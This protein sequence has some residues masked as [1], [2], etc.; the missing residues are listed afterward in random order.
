LLSTQKFSSNVVERVIESAEKN[1][2]N[3]IVNEMF[4]NATNFMILMKNK[5]GAFVL[6]KV[7]SMMQP[8]EKIIIKG[9]L[10]KSVTCSG[11]KERTKFSSIVDL[12]CLSGN[13]MKA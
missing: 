11:N 5:Y 1:I 3:K 9:H 10:L 13:N 6:Q 7:I 12:L 4:L 2:Y 8:H